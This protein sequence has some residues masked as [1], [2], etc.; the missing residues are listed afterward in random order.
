V[1]GPGGPPVSRRDDRL[2]WDGPVTDTRGTTGRPA[3]FPSRTDLT[4][5]VVLLREPGAGPLDLD[6]IV[7]GA[8]TPDVVEYTRVP[9]PYRREHADEFVA[10]AGRAWAASES[11]VFAVCAA[12]A[13]DAL[14]GMIGLHDV[15]LTGDP[16][17]V[18]E[19]GY[20][21]SPEGRG[22]GLMTRAVRLLSAWGVDE[23]GLTRISWYAVVG[24]EP[25]RRVAEACG[26]QVEGL[27]RR[28]EQRR[29]ERLDHWV[30]GLL[31][32]EVPR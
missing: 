22:R 28:G 12:E 32:E 15:D 8:T 27:L 30:G 17:G 18:A 13:P 25:S 7:H 1:V 5:G 20:W 24:N 9:V 10:E 11:A 29:G 16:G 31:A 21:M 19:I 26:Y 2:R 6:A 23:L 14:L 3:T 4:D